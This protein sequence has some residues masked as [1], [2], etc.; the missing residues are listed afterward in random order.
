MMRSISIL[1]F[2]FF[3]A[4]DLPAQS[5]SSD[6]LKTSERK[7]GSRVVL[8]EKDTT[9]KLLVDGF[10]K[11]IQMRS[12]SA[13]KENQYIVKMQG[14]KPLELIRA[15]YSGDGQKK[16]AELFSDDIEL[17]EKILKGEL[18]FEDLKKIVTEYNAWRRTID[19]MT[20]ELK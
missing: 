2:L 7:A 15:T 8:N 1:F 20:N 4:K 12:N 17:S 3:I 19:R 6:H 5:D 18:K 11:L 10:A 16:L 13:G 9:Q 14:A